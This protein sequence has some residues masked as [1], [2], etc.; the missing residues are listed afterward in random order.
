MMGGLRQ[1][2]THLCTVRTTVRW[3]DE[4]AGEPSP[5]VVAEL[6]RVYAAAAAPTTDAETV[7]LKREAATAAAN[8]LLVSSSLAPVESFPRVLWPERAVRPFAGLP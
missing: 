7:K 8:S 4:A 5:Q 6:A 1:N 2:L 3:Q